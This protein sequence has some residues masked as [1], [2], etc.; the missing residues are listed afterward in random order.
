[1]NDKKTEPPKMCELHAAGLMQEADQRSTSPQFV[2]GK[3]RRKA[4]RA[5]HLHNPLPLKKSTGDNFW[6]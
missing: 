1:M 2:C 6:G 3:C 5:E 4:N